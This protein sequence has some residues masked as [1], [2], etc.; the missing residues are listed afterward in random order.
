MCNHYQL[1]AQALSDWAI[2]QSIAAIETA[3]QT[4]SDIWPKRKAVVVCVENGA[5]IIEMM[6]WGVPMRIA[7]KRPGTQ[8]TKYVTNVRNVASPFWKSTL[9]TPAQRCLVP[10]SA[11]A[12][13]KPGKDAVTG[14]PAEYRF[15]V[16]GEAVAMFGGLWRNVE[17][18]DVFAFLTCE[19]NSL[20]KPL[21]P[22]AMP[23]IL[24]P[25][26]YDLWLHG[27][28]DDVVALQ[29]PFPAQLMTLQSR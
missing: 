22:K 7:G 18:S 3:D 4:P 14:R 19:P 29:A 23:L 10:F 27:S 20:V 24:M 15:G 2:A 8:I 1:N 21:H 26:D 9:A 13:P 12:E 25:Q 11:F 6:S 17:G 16:N 28:Y 5:R